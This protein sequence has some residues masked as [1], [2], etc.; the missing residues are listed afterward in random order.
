MTGRNYAAHYKPHPH[1]AASHVHACCHTCLSHATSHTTHGPSHTHI[2]SSNHTFSICSQMTPKGHLVTEVHS[3]LHHSLVP[4]RPQRSRVQFLSTANLADK[5]AHWAVANR[6]GYQEFGL[7]SPDDLLARSCT[8]WVTGWG[9][10]RFYICT[11]HLSTHTLGPHPPNVLKLV[12]NLLQRS[13]R[14][15]M[16]CGGCR[17]ISVC[18][19]VLESVSRMVRD[20]L[21]K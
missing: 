15:K 11:K 20:K 1:L 12:A 10:V 4:R 13:W 17:E 19:L 14:R 2:T 7:W 8:E 9:Q 5:L 18:S 21:P 16:T 3:T 6:S